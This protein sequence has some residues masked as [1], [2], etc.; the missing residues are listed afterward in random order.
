MR[1]GREKEEGLKKAFWTV[2]NKVDSSDINAVLNAIL[3]ALCAFLEQRTDELK[4]K[5]E[6]LSVLED[7]NRTQGTESLI[8]LGQS[9][10]QRLRRVEEKTKTSLPTSR[11][12]ESLVL[13]K[14]FL[15]KKLIP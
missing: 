6:K 8:L 7:Q 11:Q 13:L 14:P 3:T 9:S 15:S 5:Q 10:P 12:T 4:E 1:R 2:D